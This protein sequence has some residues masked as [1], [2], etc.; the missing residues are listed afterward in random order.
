V[1]KVIF[2]NGHLAERKYI[3]NCILGEYLGIQYYLDNNREDNQNQYDIVLDNGNIL[4]IQDYFFCKFNHE[5]EYLNSSNIPEK[6]AWANNK[7]ISSK[8]PIIYGENYIEI[9]DNEHKRIKCSIDI[10]ASIYF[11]LSR[12]EEYANKARDDHDRFPA[13]ASLS[14]RFGFLDHPVVDE[15][16]D[17][18]W[19]MLLF[20]GYKEDRKQYVYSIKLTHD[21]DEPFELCSKSNAALF[22]NIVGDVL[23]RKDYRRASKKIRLMGLGD[24]ARLPYDRYFTFDYIMDQSEKRGLKSAFYVLPNGSPE[25]SSKINIENK[26]MVKLLRSISKRGHEIGIHGHYDTYDNE[27]AFIKDVEKLRRVLEINRIYSKVFGGRQHYLRWKSPTTYYNYVDAELSYDS[28]L[29]YAD[30]AG[31]RCGTC[32]EFQPFDFI[33]RKQLNIV[34]RPLIAM[35]CSVIDERYMNLGYTEKALEYFKKLKD[36]C[37]KH[38]GNFVL[39]WHNSRLRDENEKRFYEQVLAC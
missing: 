35:E 6:I 29:S 31:F 12:W 11:M 33:K 37:R 34:E 16:V 36:E 2:S 38:N 19:Q 1:V 27:E 7:F 9:Q 23:K 3:I 39:L 14:Y 15:Y 8:F 28:T 26:L 10:F 25:Q 17:F 32:H 24:E 22:R 4:T 5:K 20:L 21:V 18:L 30:V 13:S